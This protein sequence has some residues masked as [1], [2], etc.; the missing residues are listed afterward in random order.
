MLNHFYGYNLILIDFRNPTRGD[1]F[2][3]MQL[4][5]QYMDLAEVEENEFKKFKYQA[6]A[7]KNAKIVA[8]T[9]INSSGGSQGNNAYFYDTA[10]GILTST[11]LII[12]KYGDKEVLNEDGTIKEAGTRHIVSVFKVGG[13]VYYSR[14]ENPASFS[15]FSSLVCYRRHI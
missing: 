6:L 13:D 8:E 2:N 9:I 1:S 11:I 10:K 7:E 12:S 14:V 3:F 4:V 5:N 15:D